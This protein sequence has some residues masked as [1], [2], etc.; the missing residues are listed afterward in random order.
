MT[1]R[2]DRGAIRSRMSSMDAAR[3]GSLTG[4]PAPER[5]DPTQVG[6]Q[7]PPIVPDNS[8][9]LQKNFASVPSTPK[10]SSLSQRGQRVSVDKIETTVLAGHTFMGNPAR[11]NAPKRSAGARTPSDDSHVRGSAVIDTAKKIQDTGN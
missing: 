5:G 1:L 6:P 4:A 8:Q 2:K 9:F 11:G 3:K 7:A 10:G